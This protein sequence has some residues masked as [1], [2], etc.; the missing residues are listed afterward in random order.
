MSAKRMKR[1]IHEVLMLRRYESVT[2]PDIAKKLEVDTRTVYRDMEM[3][4]KLGIAVK[5]AA[6]RDGGYAIDDS[7][8]PDQA[9]VGDPEAMKLVLLSNSGFQG[10]AGQVPDFSRLLDSAIRE[11]PPADQALF[12]ALSERIFVD[13]RDWYWR[14]PAQEFLPSIRE[15]VLGC[16]FCR[17]S[18]TERGSVEVR[19][20]DF[21]PLGLVWKGGEWY[22]VARRDDESIA[23]YRLSRMKAVELLERT[24]RRPSSFDLKEWWDRELERFGRGQLRVRLRASGAARD[25]F[26]RLVGKPDST[27]RRGDDH[28][29]ITLY[30]DNWKWLVPLIV[31]YAHDVEVIEPRELRDDVVRWLEDA[32]GRQ[33]SR[34]VTASDYTNDDARLRANY[35]RKD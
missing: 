23:R 19:Q 18:Y 8:V 11:L 35:G 34:R 20:G 33:C 7:T 6:G 5:G 27:I 16:R 26:S 22:A 28:V 1:L 30:V 25:E 32:I 14:S 21:A 10:A 9:M 3:L 12:S 4:R 29:A 15:A 13:T 17:I 24:F 31:T 2:A